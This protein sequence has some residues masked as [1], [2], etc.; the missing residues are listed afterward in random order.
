M[1]ESAYPPI[2]NVAATLVAF[3]FALVAGAAGVALE[4]FA[5]ADPATGLVSNSYAA[6]QIFGIALPQYARFR[7]SGW[8]MGWWNNRPAAPPPVKWLILREGLAVVLALSGNFRLYFQAGAQ[9]NEQVYARQSDGTAWVGQSGVSGFT[10][11]QW[12]TMSSTEGAGRAWVSSY[13]NG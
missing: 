2:E 6:G 13:A 5:W 4:Q 3:P 12:T 9:A 11:T 1:R 7:R 8:N 10:P